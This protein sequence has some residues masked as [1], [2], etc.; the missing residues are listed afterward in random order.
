MKMNL[1][2]IGLLLL[3]AAACSDKEPTGGGDGG[4]TGGNT[5]VTETPTVTSSI[6]IDLATDKAIYKQ[7]EAVNFTA[8]EVMPGAVVRYRQGARTMHTDPMTST[9]WTW[10]PPTNDHVGYMVDIVKIQDGKETVYGSIAVDVSSDWRKFP[11]YGFVGNYDRSKL[12]AGVIESE[13][14]FL[15][16]CHINGIQFYDWHNKHHWPLGGT[17]D[18]LDD[19]YTDIGNHEVATASVK[20]YIDVQHGYGMKA[21][22]YNLC[23]GALKD[24]A[25]DGVK[26]EWNIYNDNHRGYQDRHQLPDSWKSDIY[27]L[28]PG[29]HE[30]IEYLAQRNDDVYANFDFDGFHIDQLG[31]RGD[32]YDY[33]GNKVNLPLSYFT[34]I[35]GMKKKHPEK[36]LVMNAVSSYG[37]QNILETRD[38]EFA[39]NEVWDNEDQFSD[40]YNIINANDVYSGHQKNT[41]FAAYMN[42]KAPAGEFNAPGVL[43]TDAV[44]FALGGSHLELGDHMLC[45]EYFPSQ[46]VVMGKAL[47]EA[48]VHYYDFMTAYQNLLRG[49][50]LKAKVDVKMECTNTAKRLNFNSWPPQKGNV[51][52]FAKKLEDGKTVI[53]LLNFRNVDNL[54]WR[55]LN[56]TRPAPATVTNAPLSIVHHGAVTKVWVASPDY[57]GGVAVEVPF[58]QKGSTLTLTLP[59]LKYW[60]MLVI[61]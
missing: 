51:C 59:W 1:L 35:K 29:N 52:T 57:H 48:I 61:E 14:A 4:S 55:D 31:S 21:M 56:G 22:F 20:K 36:L 49:E 9:T 10:F 33:G 41:V 40:L 18:H 30:W 53:S 8:S 60:T 47:K 2:A 17:R 44:M 32:R 7:N 24:A 16:R 58:E 46:N 26:P 43:L 39:Y 42:Y 54:S 19:Y 12:S 37:Q 28:D 23:F 5:T 25:S 34:F 15:N 27:L 11:R 45:S 50:S 38:M 6:C 3:S 13:M